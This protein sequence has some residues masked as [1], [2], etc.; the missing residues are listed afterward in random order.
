[1]T[2]RRWLLPVAALLVTAGTARA[3]EFGRLPPDW[4]V[5]PEDGAQFYAS[6]DARDDQDSKDGY[7]YNR[8]EA[9]VAGTV[10]RLFDYSAQSL[11]D[12]GAVIGSR[13]RPA[14]APGDWVP[15]HLAELVMDLGVN[16]AGTAGLVT[17]IGEASVEVHWALS[18]KALREQGLVAKAEPPA[19]MPQAAPDAEARA[20]LTLNEYSSA[21]E[22][23]NQVD[24]IADTLMATGRVTDRPKMRDGLLQV[25]KDL[26]SVMVDINTY[27]DSHWDADKLGLDVEISAS[28]KVSTGFT[29]GGALRLRFEWTR[30][31]YG[32]L[33]LPAPNDGKDDSRESLRTLIAG[34]AHDMDTIGT[35]EYA[36]SG[37]DLKTIRLGIGLYLGAKFG[38]VKGKLGITGYVFWNKKAARANANY[39]AAGAHP[40]IVLDEIPLI[41]DEP[42]AAHLAY[43]EKTGVRYETVPGGDGADRAVFYMTRDKFQLGLHRAVK[44]GAFFAD[45]AHKRTGEQ[46]EN[47]RWEINQLKPQFALSLEGAIKI[48]TIGGKVSVE[49][50]YTR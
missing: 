25:A 48:V 20:D 43:A 28:G 34:I 30:A 41:D 33:A 1:M 38:V 10:D 16:A 44:M 19:P 42:K 24:R 50:T 6:D 21:L 40:H 22:L 32:A 49:L 18:Q 7:S 5:L 47:S 9:A 26:Q 23:E 39:A 29:V 37:F 3:E 15:W 13:D 36:D 14:D 31:N 45:R 17:G 2:T 8:S 12:T 46:A 11:Q 4:F 35:A 27:N